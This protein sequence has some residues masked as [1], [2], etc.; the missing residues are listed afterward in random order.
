[1]NIANNIYFPSTVIEKYFI[2]NIWQVHEYNKHTITEII[3]P[4]GT[5]EIIFNLSDKITYFNSATNEIKTLPN[6]F[7]NGINFK[8]FHLFKKG[9]QQFI[10][11]QLNVIS[12]KALFNLPATAFNNHVIDS[13]QIC[14]TLDELYQQ[15]FI[16]NNFQEQVNIISKWLCKKMLASAY[17]SSIHKIHQY[18]FNN[19]LH[20]LTVKEFSN[21]ACMCERQLRRLCNEWL[22]MNAETFLNYNKYLTALHLLHKPQLSFTQISLDAGFYDQAHFNHVF[23]SFTNLTPKAYQQYN[24]GLLGHIFIQ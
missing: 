4:K 8:P 7:I 2:S 18:F 9:K 1:M 15:L 19:K 23:K 17:L 13:A 20:N 24:K 3:L 21:N 14:T 10:G 11:I 5:V 6:C 22:G 16:K 12:L